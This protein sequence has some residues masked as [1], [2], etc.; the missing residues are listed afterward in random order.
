MGGPGLEIQLRPSWAMEQT[1]SILRASWRGAASLGEAAQV[2]DVNSSV[3]TQ[4]DRLQGLKGERVLDWSGTEMA[5]REEGHDGEPQFE[6]EAV[7]FLQCMVLQLQLAGRG[8][9]L[10]R[11]SAAAGASP[12]GAVRSGGGWVGANVRRSFRGP[13]KHVVRGP[14]RGV[15]RCFWL[16]VISPLVSNVAP[17]D[18][19][20]KL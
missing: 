17:A 9:M 5:I 7:R 6:D 11:V 16:V 4:I 3:R 13:I 19:R 14:V 15:G 12:P 10:G 1:D 8:S 18:D 2:Q 20:K